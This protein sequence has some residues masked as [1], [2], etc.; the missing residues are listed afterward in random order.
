MNIKNYCS[1]LMVVILFLIFKTSHS[2]VIRREGSAPCPGGSAQYV[3][4]SER[5][6][7][8]DVIA[9][10]VYYINNG[11]NVSVPYSVVTNNSESQAVRISVTWPS[12][13]AGHGGKVQATGLFC[14]LIDPLCFVGEDK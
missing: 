6:G 9:W 13:A 5:G 8:C 12:S 14:C 11:Q 10:G 1:L 7:V 2:Q 4:D 3:F